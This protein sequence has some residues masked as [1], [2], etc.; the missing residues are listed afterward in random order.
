LRDAAALPGHYWRVV[1]IAILF[2]LARFSEA[3]LVLRADSVG[4]AP[5][6]VPLVM[7]AM[8]AVY[9]AGAY[10][11]GLVA[12]RTGARGLLLSGLAVLACADL[13]LA[14]ARTTWHVLAGGGAW[15]LHLALTQGL[16]SKLV[17]DAAPTHLRG[18]AFGVYSL[19][20]GVAL[21]LA[22]VLAGGLWRMWGPAAT[23]YAGAGFAVLTML[24]VMALG[25]EPER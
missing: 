8:S 2:T 13:V 21:L 4:L 9:A 12:D 1:G 6:Q 10:P 18:N 3:F 7:I 25:T 16:F 14:Q 20:T 15:G 11:A 22:S 17:A 19:A 24:G 23:F 5:G